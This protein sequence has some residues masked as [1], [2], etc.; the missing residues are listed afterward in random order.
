MLSQ[1]WPDA[2][3]QKHMFLMRNAT[4]SGYGLATA[5]VEAG[6]KSGAWAQ[7]RLLES[8]SGEWVSGLRLADGV[9]LTHG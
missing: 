3:P 4:M 1:F 9:V 5:V 7:A 6:E 2:P 8:R